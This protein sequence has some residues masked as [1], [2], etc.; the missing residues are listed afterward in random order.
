MKRKIAYS[1]VAVVLIVVLAIQSCGGNSNVSLIFNQTSGNSC[2]DVDQSSATIQCGDGVL[3]F[4]GSALTPD[5]CYY[6]T[7]RIDTMNTSDIVIAITARSAA[8]D[9]DTNCVECIGKIDFSGE[10]TNIGSCSKHVSIV[11][12]GVT[13][14]EHGHE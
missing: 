8:G 1:T 3:T 6:L 10:V 7:S 4:E 2:A 9:G 13:I 5:P 11:Y 12:N 14:A